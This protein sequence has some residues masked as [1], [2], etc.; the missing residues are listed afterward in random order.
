MTLIS[1]LNNMPTFQTQKFIQDQLNKGVSQ[2]KI[3]GFLQSKGIDPSQPEQ[4]I[5]GKG[6]VNFLERLKASF[7]GAEA[8]AKAKQLEQQAG[9]SGK[10]DIG[11]IADIAGSIPSTV[12]FI[13]GG[14]LG[15]VPGAAAGSALGEAVRQGIGEAVG[16][17]KQFEPG[18]ILA[19]GAFGGIAGGAGKLISPLAKF[20]GGGISKAGT[21]I[22]NFAT[23]RTGVLGV[24]EG[25][26]RPQEVGA[27][28]KAVS[29]GTGDVIAPIEKNLRMVRGTPTKGL[30]GKIKSTFKKA[31]ENIIIKPVA[32]D[33]IKQEPKKI[34]ADFLDIQ[35]AT[36]RN[37]NNA[38]L[39]T[40]E[41]N[42]VK[43][44]LKL[45]NKQKSFTTKDVVQLKRKVAKLYRGTKNTKQ[46]DAIVTRLS[47]KDGLFNKILKENDPKF[48]KASAK[49]SSDIQF[50][51]KID[52]NILGKPGSLNVETAAS[53]IRQLAVDL[54]D[55]T[56]K[57]ATEALIKELQ[58]RTGVDFLKP[59]TDLGIAIDIAPK[60]GLRAGVVREAV[61][62]A[63]ILVNA[64]ARGAGRIA[65]QIG[66]VP[67][68]EIKQG[69]GIA[70]KVGLF[71]AL[72]QTNK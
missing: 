15:G 13:A 54:N 70:T 10:F 71:E 60:G 7:G 69:V 36:V 18:K 37:V 21:K 11:D 32:K 14:A 50:L 68:Q 28:I 66:T 3:A 2:D 30:E 63:Q 72:R 8:Q 45:V 5:A 52:A 43:N 1:I 57:E 49:Y 56:K 17:Q 29:R 67:G 65:Q 35:K 38:A 55:P 62:L 64:T 19:E 44:I 33:L 53:K 20:L 48:R 9:L 39:G 24:T 61:R 41:K 22:G 40:T 59:I 23:T 26:K 27:A 47:G 58:K 4:K 16:T 25:F 51:D 6:Q 31:E 42:T 46:S 34:I 12:G